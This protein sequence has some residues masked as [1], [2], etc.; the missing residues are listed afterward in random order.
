[1]TPASRLRTRLVA[2]LCVLL[3]AASLLAQ[4]PPAAPGPVE[5]VDYVVIA[6]GAPLA[7]LDGRIEVVEV[8]SYGCIHCFRFQAPVD[9]WLSK[10]DP[11]VRFTYLP[12]AFSA[13][14]AFARGFFVAQAQ[15]L[16]K[17]THHALFSAVHEQSVLPR[18]GAGYDA[19][20]RWYASH[21]APSQPD[22]LAAMASPATDEKMNQA[23]AFAA[24]SGVQGT[25]TLI[26]NGR[27]RVQSQSLQGALDTASQL[28][29]RERA[30]R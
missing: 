27:Y 4:S 22:F 11:D 29:A 21:G 28:I 16:F 17:Q 30:A 19:V 9:A 23:H 2:L 10:Q 12:A 25:P 15:G 14:D 26:I 1:M 18:G 24:R 5:N 3:P 6:E 8:F 7:P 13:N 20:A